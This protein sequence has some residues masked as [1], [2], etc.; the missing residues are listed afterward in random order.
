MKKLFSCGVI[1]GS[2]CVASAAQSVLFDFDTAPVHAPLPVSVSAGQLTAQLSATGQGFSVQRA[3]VLGFTPAGFAGNCIYPNS[4]FAA[5]LVVSFSQPLTDFSIMYAP[6]EY[7]CDSSALMRVTALAGGLV[8]GSGTATADPPG[9][10]PTGTLSFSSLRVFD[11]VVIHYESAPP[12][13]GDW[14]PIFMAD[15]MNVTPILIGDCNRDNSVNFTDL[16][17]L[18]QHYG[19]PGNLLSGDFDGDGSVTFS[20]LLALAQHY[21]QIG[22]GAAFVAGQVPETSFVPLLGFAA[23]ACRRRVQVPCHYGA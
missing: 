6:E 23:L 13:G 4:V 12:T 19:Q 10:W 14:G 16:L 3:D 2:A 5:D 17:T 9:T 15:N 11:H 1:L 21:G 20:D 22:A 8:V 7:A 18:A